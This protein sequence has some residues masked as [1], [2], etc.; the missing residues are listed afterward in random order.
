M[1]I[2][3]SG[4]TFDSDGST[5]KELEAM[6]WRDGFVPPSNV[7]GHLIRKSAGGV[8]LVRIDRDEIR[9]GMKN[10]GRWFTE[11][12]IEDFL[13]SGDMF[14]DVVIGKNGVRYMKKEPLLD[15]RLFE[16]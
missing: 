13:A 4:E 6:Y 1:I 7:R 15:E 14:V 10:P 2:V 8:W 9:R 12:E 5:A 16:I 11:S 3:D